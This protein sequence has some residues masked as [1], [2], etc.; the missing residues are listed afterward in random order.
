MPLGL[1]PLAAGPVVPAMVGEFPARSQQQQQD[2][3][4]ELRQELQQEQQKQSRDHLHRLQ[5]QR[6]TE[7]AAQEEE[8]RAAA[9]RTR[10]LELALDSHGS[11]KVQQALE[12]S[13]G[14]DQE[15]LVRELRG[16]VSKALQSPHGNHVLQ[17]AIAVM[18]PSDLFFIIPELLQWGRPSTL[19]K[20]PY[21]C[22]VLERLIEFFPAH[23]LTDFVGDL[24]ESIPDLSKHQ[25]GNFVVQHLLEH[26]DAEVRERIAKVVC[27]QLA[28]MAANQYACAVVDKTLAYADLE[29]RRRL[30]DQA[31]SHPGL[32]VAV[33]TKRWGLGTAERLVSLAR[34]RQVD[35]AHRQLA[36]GTTALQRTAS[37]RQL[38]ELLRVDLQHIFEV[39]VHS[40]NGDMPLGAFPLGRRSCR[41][42]DAEMCAVSNILILD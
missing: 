17:K 1:L 23:R 16:H 36:D 26:G 5:A 14:A 13:H 12:E 39:R 32:L 30:I 3:Q 25:Y 2:L 24:L 38:L 21:G 33:A 18:W 20:H 29:D 31:L 6:R 35:E 9:L 41:Q 4:R 40:D 37:G 11:R 34:G 15:I 22:R 7:P 8:S 28:G 19:A 10:V 27:K 42:T